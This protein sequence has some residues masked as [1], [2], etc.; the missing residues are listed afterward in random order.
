M[1]TNIQQTEADANIQQTDQ[2]A[3]PKNNNKIIIVA[4]VIVSL[5]TVAGVLAYN[6]AFKMS[7]KEL[8]FLAEKQSIINISENIQ[9]AK[10]TLQY[11]LSEYML[12]NPVHSTVEISGDITAKG[13]A[14]LESQWENINKTLRDSSLIIDSK[15]DPEARKSYADLIYRFKGVDLINAQFYNDNDTIAFKVP[16]LFDKYFKFKNDG[17]RDNLAKLGVYDQNIPNRFITNED[18]Y[19]SIKIPQ[20]E[21]IDEILKDYGEFIFNFFKEEEFALERNAIVSAS[22]REIKCSKITLKLDEG[23]IKD[24]LIEAADKVK[25][26]EKLKDILIKNV[27]SLFELFRDA[28]YIPE[29]DSNINMS[30]SE[31]EK[32]FND[33]LSSF[34]Y[35]VRELKFNDGLKYSLWVD[36]KKNIV[37]REL[38]FEINHQDIDNSLYFELANSNWT[39]K[40][41]SVDKALS[42]V[43]Y[44]DG[45]MSEDKN[46]LNTNIKIKEFPEGK[47][48]EAQSKVNISLLAYE[49]SKKGLDL[50]IELDKKAVKT[51]KDKETAEID[52]NISF[53]NEER[54]AYDFEGKLN[55]QLEGAI[56][57]GK[58]NINSAL[59]LYVSAK[60]GH[61]NN[62]VSFDIN[63]DVENN[64][65]LENELDFPEL[66]E[67][68]S[69]DI[70]ELDPIQSF[71]IMMEIQS[72][73]E[74]FFEKNRNIL[75]EMGAEGLI[76]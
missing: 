33:G 32:L 5:L 29:Y 21:E 46:E 57:S 4:A 61:K 42:I 73:T 76:P 22:D 8:F 45:G 26:D 47:N 53:E 9:K 54:N 49:N 19:N 11:Q 25:E 62:A 34:K 50:N 3:K 56:A 67:V 71:A 58:I 38:Y 48:G 35:S 20:K 14:S 70:F 30:K 65:S 24:L 15:S 37:K 69:V 59:E 75:N 52:F 23:R 60:D 17:I 55:Q 74:E 72:R 43:I 10:N 44:P 7:P 6:L 66:S 16:V 64:I 28:G 27:Y 18:I 13:N 51:G 63:L 39:N 1:G 68:N 41:K 2:V 40:D 12:K 31:I 36:K